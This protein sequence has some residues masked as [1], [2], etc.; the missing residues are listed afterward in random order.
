M[1]PS[2]LVFESCLFGLLVSSA[3]KKVLFLMRAITAVSEGF[4]KGS[5]FTELCVH[6]VDLK[7]EGR[8]PVC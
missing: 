5:C 7:S 2:I 4:C 3:S 6:D 8:G 1:P